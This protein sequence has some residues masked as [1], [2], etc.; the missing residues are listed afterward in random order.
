[1]FK[2]EEEEK[3]AGEEK[4]EGFVRRSKRFIPMNLPNL[5]KESFDAKGMEEGRSKV[6]GLKE[7][8]REVFLGVLF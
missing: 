6:L 3:E 7:K 5:K 8:W 4:M 1:M 2:E